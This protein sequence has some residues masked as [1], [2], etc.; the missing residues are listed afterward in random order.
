MTYT[1]KEMFKTLQGEGGQA[2]RAAMFCRF[3]GCNLWNGRE[4]DRARAQCRFCD[5]D[6]VGTYGTGG[7]RFPSAGALADAL[8]A[9][10]TMPITT[11]A[12]SCSPAASPC[13]SSMPA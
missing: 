2:G 4:V 10:G 11:A 5:T 12:T 3:T 7:G 13:C 1:V 6:F 8:E 9:S